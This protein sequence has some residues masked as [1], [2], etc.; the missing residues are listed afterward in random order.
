MSNKQTAT[1]LERLLFLRYTCIQFACMQLDKREKTVN[2][3]KSSPIHGYETLPPCPG[4]FHLME[5]QKYEQ[6]TDLEEERKLKLN[7]STFSVSKYFCEIEK[8]HGFRHINISRITLHH[9]FRLIIA[10]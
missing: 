2:S 5:L 8:F 1:L 10:E 3:D 4:E 6:E 9:F 7:S